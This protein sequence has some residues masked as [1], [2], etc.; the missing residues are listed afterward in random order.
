[1][2]IGSEV[3]CFGRRASGERF[4]RGHV[5]Q[6]AR[7]RI[8]GRPVWW[9]QGCITPGSLASPLGLRGHS[10]CAT[11][12][13]VG[14]PVPAGLQDAVRAVDPVLAVSQV[15]QVFVARFLGDDGER[16]RAAITG[17]WTVLRP[18]LLDRPARVPRL[19]TT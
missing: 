13:A 10:V 7:I 9:E 11:L 2:Y 1:V 19:W 6:R 8:D 18:H 16:A 4:T 17:A 15:K 12:V 3:L 14:K 5:G